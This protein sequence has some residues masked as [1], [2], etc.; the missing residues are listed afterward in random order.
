MINMYQRQMVYLHKR[1]FCAAI[2]SLN[3]AILSSITDVAYKELNLPGYERKLNFFYQTTVTNTTLLVYLRICVQENILDFISKTF[4][5]ES[6]VKLIWEFLFYN[7]LSKFKLQNK[8][9][10]DLISFFC[11][12]IISSAAHWRPVPASD[13]SSKGK[14]SANRTFGLSAHLLNIFCGASYQDQ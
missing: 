6:F 3:T 2:R 9:S 4:T 5:E 10:S 14:A 12:N 13:A 7:Y 8:Q 1:M 11:Y